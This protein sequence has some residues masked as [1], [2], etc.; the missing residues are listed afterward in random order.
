[1]TANKSIIIRRHTRYTLPNGLPNGVNM[2]T[3]FQFGQTCGG[4]CTLYV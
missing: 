2:D 3:Q 4:K 1:M